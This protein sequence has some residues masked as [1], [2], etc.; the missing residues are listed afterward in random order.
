M[1]F[2]MPPSL[3]S[4][5]SMLSGSSGVPSA[6]DSS[7]RKDRTVLVTRIGNLCRPSRPTAS[8][9]SVTA[10]SLLVIEPWP[11]RAVHREPHPVH[12]LL[13]GLDQ[14]E[15]QVLVDGE[16]EAA[17][18]ADRLRHALEQ[19]RVVVDQVP[20]A[21][22]AARLLVGEE[23]EHDV[24][25]GLRPVRSRSRTTASVMASMSFMSTAPRPQTQ[26]STISP[27]NG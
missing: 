19:L 2:A 7:S 9:S 11:G 13:G 10:L 26:P 20:R 5:S 1:S 25:R 23:G 4:V 16:R 8:D 15:P 12:A 24:A 22:H 18:L 17:D 21:E 3:A 27:E 14:V 6:S